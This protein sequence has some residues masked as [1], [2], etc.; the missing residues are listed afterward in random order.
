MALG[1]MVLWPSDAVACSEQE[2]H[3]IKLIMFTLKMVA[4]VKHRVCAMAKAG[5][6]RAGVTCLAAVVVT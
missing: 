5:G 3:F 6:I 1:Q 4:S 2:L